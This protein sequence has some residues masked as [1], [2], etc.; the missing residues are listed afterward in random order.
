MRKDDRVQCSD[1]EDINEE[2][3]GMMDECK[4]TS[5]ARG[6][7]WEKDLMFRE[8]ERSNCTGGEK[9]VYQQK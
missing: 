3:G 9:K 8:K 7:S 4:S 2:R 5:F 1:V 6:D